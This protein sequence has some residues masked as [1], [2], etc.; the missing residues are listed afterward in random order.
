VNKKITGV[1][2]SVGLITGV[3]IV[4][5]GS[6]SAATKPSP[7]PTPRAK[8][9]PHPTV[10]VTV[11]ATPKPTPSPTPDPTPTPSVTKP[12]TASESTACKVIQGVTYGSGAVELQSGII[13]LPTFGTVVGAPVGAIA[14]TTALVSTG[15]GFVSGA[16]YDAICR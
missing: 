4:T 2:L 8:P 9:T 5:A 16:V 11:T 7:A 10:T 13:A 1:V 15:V 6:A 12:S 3:G 14:G